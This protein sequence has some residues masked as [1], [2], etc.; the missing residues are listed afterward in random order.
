APLNAAVAG[1]AL[2]DVDVELPVGGLARDLDLELL[3]DVGLVQGTA[4]VRANVGQGRLVNLVD[5]FGAGRLAV[6]LGAV[7]PAARGAGRACVRASWAGR[8][9]GPWR[10][11]RP[12][13]C[14][15]GGP[16]RADGGA[17]RSRLA[18]RGP[19][20][21][22]IGSWHTGPLPCRNY[23]QQRDGQPRRR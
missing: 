9:A 1:L 13:A 17:A 8:W 22:G 2:P 19:V 20:A 12:G 3:G 7:V 18:G 15:H 5:L 23:T 10:R 6:G 4:A 11:G 16:R 21:E 14:R